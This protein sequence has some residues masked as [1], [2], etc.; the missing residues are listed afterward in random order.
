ME[1]EIKDL[2][3]VCSYPKMEREFRVYVVVLLYLF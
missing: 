2:S 3:Y 1:A